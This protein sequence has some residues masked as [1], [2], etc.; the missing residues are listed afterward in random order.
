LPLQQKFT[1]AGLKCF[2]ARC[3]ANKTRRGKY[4]NNNNKFKNYKNEEKNKK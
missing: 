1:I 3:R 4:S 2:S